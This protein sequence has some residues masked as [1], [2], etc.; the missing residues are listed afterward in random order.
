MFLRTSIFI[1]TAIATIAVT[2]LAPTSAS[3]KP[4]KAGWS[5]GGGIYQSHDNHTIRTFCR[6]AGGE[7][8]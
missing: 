2:A 5:I 6:K 7:Q 4:I 8:E 3:A 1:L